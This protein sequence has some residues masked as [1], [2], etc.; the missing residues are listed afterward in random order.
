M[1][2]AAAI[3]R[4][5]EAQR[6]ALVLQHW[7]GWSPAESANRLGR[8]RA[9]VAGLLKRGLSRLRVEMRTRTRI[10]TTQTIPE[11]RLIRR[12]A[13]CRQNDGDCRLSDVGNR[14]R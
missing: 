2:L 11:R 7:K 13:A 8:T 10:E 3:D 5:P 9:D 12:G 6:E 1:Q 4:L 14:F